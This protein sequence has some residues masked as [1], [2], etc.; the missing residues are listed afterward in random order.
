MEELRN[1]FVYMHQSMDTKKKYIG[2]TKQKHPEN[3]W[4]NGDGYI[5]NS[6]FYGD[7]KQ[8]GWDRFTHTILDQNLT[9]GEAR[10]KENEY[11]KKFDTI[12][13]GYNN[14]YSISLDQESFDYNSFKII[15]QTDIEYKPDGDYFIRIPNALIRTNLSSFGLNR[16]FYV[17]WI[18]IDRHR[19]LEN[20]SYIT[21]GEI[22]DCCE[23]LRRNPRP[24]IVKEI[25]KC[26]F[27]L[28]ANNYIEI[29]YLD[30]YNVPYDRCIT[31]KIIAQN[32]DCA[33]NFTKIYNSE[34]DAL[35]C[36]SY[37]P[38]KNKIGIRRENILL[39]YL[40]IKSYI[41]SRSKQTL[42]YKLKEKDFPILQ[43]QMKNINNEDSYKDSP[44]AFW[45]PIQTMSTELGMSK[46]TLDECLDYL[47]QDSKNHTALLVKHKTGYIPRSDKQPPKQAPN[48]Y[49][50]NQKG[51]QNEIKWAVN[52]MMQIYNINAFVNED[53]SKNDENDD[54]N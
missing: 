2:I 54:F 23:Y 45:K 40:Y 13:S 10:T 5:Y 29:D 39:V 8:Y 30:I 53:G 21:I 48:I 14:V 17:I 36:T 3:R 34:F 28:E 38:R 4:M 32:F 11:I 12:N 24:K 9:H 52:K 18:L 33:G 41:G 42:P 37:A 22:L 25:I 47:T 26:L 43:A 46:K 49:V 6:K 7:I 19:S 44:L 50:L 1:Y 27:F 31:L 51:Y 35:L 15:N 16:V 20:R